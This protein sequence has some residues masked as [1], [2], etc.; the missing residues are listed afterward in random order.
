MVDPVPIRRL[1]ASGRL[2]WGCQKR[3][4]P[5]AK[6]ETDDGQHRDEGDRVHLVALQHIE[7]A[8]GG[9]EVEEVV[10]PALGQRDHMIQ[11][12]VLDRQWCLSVEV[13]AEVR[14]VDGAPHPR[15]EEWDV[16]LRREGGDKGS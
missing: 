8:R 16:G 13:A 11:R 4:R 10:A 9:D 5:R 2:L 1:L 6:V 15:I 12:H 14:P 3:K 7:R